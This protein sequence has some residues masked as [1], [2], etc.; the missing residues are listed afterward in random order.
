[1]ECYLTDPNP[2]PKRWFTRRV[3]RGL[4]ASIRA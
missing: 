4:L 2:F 1:V 3:L